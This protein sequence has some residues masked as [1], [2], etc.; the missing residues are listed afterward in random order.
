MAETILVRGSA[1]Q[2]GDIVLHNEKDILMTVETVVL[3]LV[4]AN[5]TPDVVNAT[6]VT[7]CCDHGVLIGAPCEACRG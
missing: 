4:D 7:R 2:A 1:I 3:R 5:G 6:K